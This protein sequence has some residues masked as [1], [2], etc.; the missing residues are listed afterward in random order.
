MII[1]VDGSKAAREEDAARRSE[2]PVTSREMTR[3][4]TTQRIEMIACGRRIIPTYETINY[5][6]VVVDPPDDFTASD[7]IHH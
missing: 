4:L 1:G 2:T 6:A 3:R 5:R 7:L